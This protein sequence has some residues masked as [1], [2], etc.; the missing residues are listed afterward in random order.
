MKLHL[1]IITCIFL[2]P[3]PV[4]GEITHSKTSKPP[5]PG[6]CQVGPPEEDEESGA[7][8]Q[9]QLQQLVKQI[10]VKV[11]GE[12]HVASGT[13]LAQAGNSY[14][15]VTNSHVVRRI[16]PKS[17]NIQTP[18]GKTHPVKL[19]DTNLG[20]LDLAILEFNSN[21]QYCLP[22]DITNFDIDIDTPV[23]AGG[24]PSA[25]NNIVLSG[26][27]VE[28]IQ[29]TILSIPVPQG[30]ADARSWIERG[31]QLWRLRR[32]DEAVQAFDR[33]IAQKPAFIDL[34]YYGQGLA[35]GSSGQLTEAAAALELAV[36][37]RPDFVPAWYHLSS[38][39]GGLQQ[40][41]RALDAI[42]QA[43][44]LEPGNPNLY[45]QKRG[46][47]SDL[48]RYA[49]AELAMNQ[50]IKLSPRPA[51]YNNRGIVYVNQQKWDL[52]LADFTQAIGINRNDDLAY[53]NRGVV[54]ADLQKWDLALADFTRFRSTASNLNS[55]S[56]NWL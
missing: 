14:L 9:K 12:R 24:Y 36:K 46:V 42:N 30:N 7:Y 15:V 37:A 20:K 53:Y 26:G 32:H 43:I 21:Q 39:Y 16:N 4:L 52:A 22:P 49:E 50:A 23:M 35:L 29:N 56:K 41:D 6:K 25:E 13:I 55:S 40:L 28:S 5:I 31:N 27:E 47:L 51:F 38:V 33:A 19:L 34:A 18:D 54:Y 2:L 3:L 8:S 48:K 11:R 17:L 10:T 1:A 44:K 45:N